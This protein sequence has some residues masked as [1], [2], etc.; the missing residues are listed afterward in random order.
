[1]F[2]VTRYFAREI[3][4][5]AARRFLLFADWRFARMAE[6]DSWGN[7]LPISAARFTNIFFLDRD[8]ILN[9]S[10]RSLASTRSVVDPALP[11]RERSIKGA[12]G[13][14]LAFS[15]GP[16]FATCIG[17]LRH[18]DEPRGFLNLRASR[19]VRRIR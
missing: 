2:G 3:V 16:T 5:G 19:R 17:P 11:D 10:L 18:P 8:L 6:A 7:V 4:G 15:T 9:A 12:D 14:C 13:H 1:M